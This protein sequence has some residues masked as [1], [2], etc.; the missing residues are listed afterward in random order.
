M[1]RGVAVN[2]I[3]RRRRAGVCVCVRLLPSPVRAAAKIDDEII[4]SYHP[5]TRLS[6][7]RNIITD[8]M[9]RAPRRPACVRGGNRRRHGTNQN[10]QNVCATKQ[11]VRRQCTHVR[12]ST[13]KKPQGREREVGFWGREGTFT[14]TYAACYTVTHAH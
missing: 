11:P 6:S 13:G 3:I 5:D 1:Q 9:S 2:K 7:P 12:M 8:M 10:A 4:S 14:G